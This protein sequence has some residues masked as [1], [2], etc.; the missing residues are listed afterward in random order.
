MRNAGTGTA[1]RAAPAGTGDTGIRTGVGQRWGQRDTHRKHTPHRRH[2]H[3]SP[4]RAARPGRAAPRV[5]LRGSPAPRLT[6]SLRAE[7]RGGAGGAGGGGRCEGRGAGGPCAP[8]SSPPRRPRAG[9]ARPRAPR[10]SAAGAAARGR[11]RPEG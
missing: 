4:L 7:P 9:A 10:A 3:R 5:A 1:A 2:P 8:P 11:L 6:A